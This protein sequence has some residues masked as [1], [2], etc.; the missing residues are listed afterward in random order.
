M[1]AGTLTIN[2]IIVPVFIEV[3]INI[4]LAINFLPFKTWVS[5]VDPNINISKIVIQSIDMFGSRIGF[6]K[7]QVFG[8]VNGIPLPGV[9][10]SRGNSVAVLP[11]LKS[12]TSSQR[13]VIC[14]EQYR[15]PAGRKMIEIPAGMM[16]QNGSFV[17]VAAKE[18]EEETGIIMKQTDLIELTS[19][20][21]YPSIGGC[22]EGMKIMYYTKDVSDEDLIKLNGKIT[23]C[24]DE[25]EVIQ[26]KLIKYE[27]LHLISDMKAMTAMLLLERKLVCG[28][29][30]PHF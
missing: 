7:Y 12:M 1:S 22:D 30:A 9:V 28:Q 8:K 10:F 3:P 25:N 5:N 27:D 11:V 29:I 23:G 20:L 6:M 26:L 16:D 4:D 19:D 17:G 24:T 2:Q 21:V 18:M 14:T 13:Y 15:M